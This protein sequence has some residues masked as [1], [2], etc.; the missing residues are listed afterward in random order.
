MDKSDEVT[1]QNETLWDSRAEN[2]DAVFG[3]SRWLQ[4]KLISQIDFGDNPRLLEI[5]CGTGWAVRYSAKLARIGGKSRRNRS[6][7]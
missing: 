3:F 4:K 2:Y 1:K 7:H 6:D 5:A